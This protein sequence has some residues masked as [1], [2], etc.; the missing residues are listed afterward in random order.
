MSAL[1]G[2]LRKP[3]RPANLAGFIFLDRQS[4]ALQLTADLG[5]TLVVHTTE[6]ASPPPEAPNHL[7]S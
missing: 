5:L 1:L 6:H 7:A 3:D 4:E 2:G